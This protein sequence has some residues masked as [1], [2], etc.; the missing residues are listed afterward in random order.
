[1][2]FRLMMLF[3][4]VASIQGFFIAGVLFFYK[5]GVP[6][7][8]LA[9]FILLFSI[10]LL[11]WVG[12]WT[13]HYNSQ[14]LFSNISISFSALYGPILFFYYRYS[15]DN[16]AFNRKD[17]WHFALP[18]LILIK[19][20]PYYSFNWFGY[21]TGWR[22]LWNITIFEDTDVVPYLLI[23]SV[24]SYSVFLWYKYTPI[25]KNYTYQLSWHRYLILFFFL[26]GVN[27]AIYVIW[28]RFLGGIPIYFD[29]F[30][31]FLI[32][33]MIYSVM[34]LAYIRPEVFAG[35]SIVQSIKQLKYKKSGLSREQGQKIIAQLNQLMQQEKPYLESGL[36]VD[37]VS[38]KIQVSSHHI[39]Q[40]IN[41]QLKMNFSD[42]VNHFRIKEAENL[43]KTTTKQEMNIIEIAYEV[44][45]NNK[46]SFNNAFK[47]VTGV[48]ATEY[49][50]SLKP[51]E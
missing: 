26:F 46:N 49:R 6:N 9:L 25:F 13:Y 47:K 17:L 42:Y 37:E 41:E 43:L 5:K 18:G 27:S 22:F 10:C 3:F 44:G 34:V 23:A 45:F 12:F 33:I 15:V 31:S 16:Y 39:S 1:M 21:K 28:N 48:T 50:G 32:V 8:L 40:A 29:L 51:T 14:P 2:V 35:L 20:L 38:K 4:V 7:R 30:V 36:K 24:F 11:D 19:Y